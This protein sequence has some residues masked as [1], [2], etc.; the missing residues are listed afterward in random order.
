MCVKGYIFRF[1]HFWH[2]C[3]VLLNTAHTSSAFSLSLPP[4]RRCRP[5]VRCCHVVMYTCL[6]VVG[7]HSLGLTDLG[8]K[9]A[10]NQG[11]KTQNFYYGGVTRRH[12]F[13]KC[14]LTTILKK[15][16]R[17]K[18]SSSDK[19]SFISPI[20]YTDWLGFQYSN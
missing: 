14:V 12:S 5:S 19:V 16:I 15:Y 8:R 6:L 2:K 10:C 18:T 1:C 17:K 3:A 4:R 13:G 7:R 20:R 9:G 11:G